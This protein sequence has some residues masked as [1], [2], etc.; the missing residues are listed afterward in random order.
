M[1]VL[2]SLLVLTHGLNVLVNELQKA[3]QRLAKYWTKRKALF[4][5]DKFCL[6]MTQEGALRDDKATLDLGLY[7][8]LPE[9]DNS[10][11][12]IFFYDPTLLAVKTH[13]RDSYVSNTH[14]H[15]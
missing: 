10:N 13:K 8:L 3:S 5:P 7:R 4:G 14:T 11:R 2:K 12:L 6:P 9:P 15:T 1:L